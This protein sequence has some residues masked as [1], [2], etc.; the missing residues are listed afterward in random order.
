[1]VWIWLDRDRRDSVIAE[2]QSM[3]HEYPNGKSFLW[4]LA[5]AFRKDG[6]FGSAAETYRQL[7]DLI[8]SSPGNFYN[9]VECDYWLYQCYDRIGFEDKADRLATNFQQYAEDIPRESANRQRVK[10]SYLLRRAH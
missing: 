5:E 9:M 4:P 8:S 7:R 10:I 2:A 1:M 3:S 6:E